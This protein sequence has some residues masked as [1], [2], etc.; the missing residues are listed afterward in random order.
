[1]RKELKDKL[2]QDPIKWELYKQKRKEHYKRNYKRIKADP[3]RYEKLKNRRRKYYEK[4]NSETK[5]TKFKRR[6]KSPY[7][8][9]KQG[10]QRYKCHVF[11]IMANRCNIRCKISKV[12]AIDLWRLTKKQGIRCTISGERLTVDN[13]SLDHIIPVSKGGT[14][15]LDNLRLVTRA[16][17]TAKHTMSD[18][19]F[20]LFCQN[21]VNRNVHSL[22]T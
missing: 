12:K 3:I 19:E 11:Q 1:M 15:A 8:Q 14:N 10:Y 21:I 18:D 20:F 2:R 7:Y 17:N 5:E 4:I 16:V 6:S 9:K 22:F 13:I